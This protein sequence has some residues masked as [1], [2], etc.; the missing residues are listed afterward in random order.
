MTENKFGVIRV[1]SLNEGVFLLTWFLMIVMTIINGNMYLAGMRFVMVPSCLL[2]MG[3]AIVPK[4]FGPVSRYLLV[5]LLL[6]SATISTYLSDVVTMN[7]SYYNLLFCGVI[8]V[9]VTSVKYDDYLLKGIFGFYLKFVLLICIIMCINR[10]VGYGISVNNRISIRY[11]GITKDVN[12]LTAFLVPGFTLN[13]YRALIGNKKRCYLY[14]A[15]IIVAIFFAGSRSVFISALLSSCII[16]ISFFTGRGSLNKKL[17]AI[18]LILVF[19]VA[20]F[21][22]FQNNPLFSRMTTTTGYEDNARLKIWDYAMEAFYRR[23]WIGSGI[24]SGT[25]FSQLSVKWVTH[26]AFLD[27]LTAQGIIGAVIFLML[28]IKTAWVGKANR[29]F[30][31]AYMITS[32]LPLFFVNGYECATFW[33]P[34]MMCTLMSDF[35]KSGKNIRDILD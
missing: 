31:I 29:S 11:F 35:C 1:R 27:V 2:L 8:Y 18:I 32:F 16:V 23:P 20:F 14:A 5:V 21:V 26:N 19:L 30:M 28:L 4:K 6:L 3:C 25:Y 12:Y 7:P 24:N 9:V 15:V 17:S 10:V 22:L 33:V 34:M 13:L